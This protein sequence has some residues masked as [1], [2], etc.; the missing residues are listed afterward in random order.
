MKEGIEIEK[1][2]EMVNKNDANEYN[3]FFDYPY[4]NISNAG[5]N[6]FEIQSNL[7]F[8]S[9]IG[10]VFNFQNDSRSNFVFNLKRN[11]VNKKIIFQNITFYNY[12]LENL[13]TLK[14]E[15]ID[16][17][18]FTIEFDNCTFIDNSGYI[19]NINFAP[20]KYFSNSP[21]V[22]FNNCQ[23]RYRNMLLNINFVINNINN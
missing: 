3:V 8:N 15:E 14:I 2:A 1:I 22:I 12:I 10:T 21:Q 16:D 5:R 6:Q 18:N 19:I 11:F 9:K 20:F 4:Y 7:I 13:I 23:F 17:N